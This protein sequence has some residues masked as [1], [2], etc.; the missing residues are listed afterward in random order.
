MLALLLYVM[1]ISALPF[2]RHCQGWDQKIVWG[3]LRLLL[4]LGLAYKSVE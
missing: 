4:G 1:C 2:G 3:V